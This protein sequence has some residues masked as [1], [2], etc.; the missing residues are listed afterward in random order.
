MEWELR[1]YWGNGMLKQLLKET[2]DGSTDEAYGLSSPKQDTRMGKM[3][4]SH[5]GLKLVYMWVKQ[6]KITENEFKEL[7]TGYT[8][9]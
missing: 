3:W 9:E 7:I 4:S 5:D 8:K 1:S 6:N 2:D